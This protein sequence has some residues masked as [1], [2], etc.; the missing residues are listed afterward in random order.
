MSEAANGQP[1]AA[2]RIRRVRALS[3]DGRV[4]AE[5]EVADG[6]YRLALPEGEEVA[7]ILALDERGAPV[8]SVER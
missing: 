3:F 4:L 7:A 1:A 2:E 6:A 5:A 8:G